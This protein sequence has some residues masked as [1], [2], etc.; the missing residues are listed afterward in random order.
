MGVNDAADLLDAVD[1]LTKPV[2]EHIPQTDD[3]G[4]YLRTH[5]V[6]HPP[7]LEQLNAAITSAIGSGGGGG[8]ATGMVLNS[9]ALYRSV[10]VRTEIADWGHILGVKRTRNMVDDL[11]AWYDVFKHTG[12]D[13]GYHIGKMRGWAHMIRDLI[14]PPKRIPVDVPCPVCHATKW[15]NADGEEQPWPVVY[16]YRREDAM[17]T[18]AAMCRAPDCGVTWDGFDSV[19]ELAAELAEKGRTDTPSVV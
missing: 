12:R 8:S 1:A 18:V 15:I 17:G 4:R 14:D 6:E 2:I 10:M 3:E 19:E 9:D 13:E 5:T 16:E 7:L 11:R